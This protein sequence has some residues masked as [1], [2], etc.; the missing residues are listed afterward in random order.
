MLSQTPDQI[1]DRIM[2]LEDGSRIQILAPIVTA[3]KGEHAK[4]LE[5]ARKSGYSKVRIN[6]TTCDIFDDLPID[7]NKKNNIS[8]VIDR[9]L[10]KAENRGRIAKAVELSIK[11]AKGNVMVEAVNDGEAK[12]YTYSTGLSDPT[13][14]MSLPNPEPRLFSF[15]S[16][17]GAC[18]A[19]NGLGYLFEFDPD[20]I[21]NDPAL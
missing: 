10:V 2:D 6:N 4:E 20:L 15:N 11:M 5:A 14:G 13:T 1:V 3:R 21:V 16:P 12:L 18:P 9:L 7:K 19:C 8:I 17:V